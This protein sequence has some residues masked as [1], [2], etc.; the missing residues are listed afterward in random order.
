M[1]SHQFNEPFMNAFILQLHK[2]DK[3]LFYAAAYGGRLREFR[4]E[5][6]TY[7]MGGELK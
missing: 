4:D 5:L 7:V 3:A 2:K 6:L 1:N